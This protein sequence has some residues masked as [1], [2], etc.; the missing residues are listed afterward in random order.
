M[1]GIAVVNSWRDDALC[2]EVPGDL[3]FA[4]HSLTAEN[5][6]AKDIC[7]VCPVKAECLEFALVN[8]IEYGCW[9]G[10]LPLERRALRRRLKR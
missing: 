1:D 2:A 9:G 6:R 8:R 10:L 7:G 4:D 3:W 5:R